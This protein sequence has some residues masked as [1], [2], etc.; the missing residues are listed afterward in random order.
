[1]SKVNKIK[2]FFVPPSE[3]KKIGD[4][5]R[6]LNQEKMKNPFQKFKMNMYA[7]GFCK[8]RYGLFSVGRDGVLSQTHSMKPI[9]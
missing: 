2:I 9:Y 8:L 5:V 6:N 7:F 3:F 4:E 1:M